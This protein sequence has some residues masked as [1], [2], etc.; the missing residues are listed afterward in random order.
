MSHISLIDSAGVRLFVENTLVHLVVHIHHM[1][2]GPSNVHGSPSFYFCAITIGTLL[3]VI[4]QTV[5]TH[6]LHSI[7]RHYISFTP[8]SYTSLAFN[9]PHYISFTPLVQLMGGGN[10]LGTM[11]CHR[12]SIPFVVAAGVVHHYFW[13]SSSLVMTYHQYH[14][15]AHI[16]LSK[17]LLVCPILA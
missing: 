8:L 12:I 1:V 9:I 15:S 7:S 5:H 11:Y 2:L 14:Q 4:S 16:K 17:Q 6:H 3:S 10:N 13:N